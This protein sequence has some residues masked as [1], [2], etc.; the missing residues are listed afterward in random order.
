KGKLFS[1]LGGGFRTRNE[2]L[3]FGTIEGRLT[4]YP[5]TM[6]LVNHFALTL[7]SNLRLRIADSYTQPPWMAAYR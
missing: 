1:A 4:Y 5:R 3:I 2:N 6:G 7:S